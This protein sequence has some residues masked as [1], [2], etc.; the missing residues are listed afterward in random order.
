M[1]QIPFDYDKKYYKIMPKNMMH[2]KYKFKLGLNE[3]KLND[4]WD[5]R[6][7]IGGGFYFCNLSDVPEWIHLYP[8]G[9]I[10]DISIPHDAMVSKR[11]NKYKTNKI[12]VSNPIKYNDFILAH[13]LEYNVIESNGLY[14]CYIKKPTFDICMRAI[15]RCIFAI[16]Y[17]DIENQTLELCKKV[18]KQNGLLLEFIKNK[19]FDICI[20][21]IEQNSMALKFVP[22][23]YHNYQ[24][25]VMAIKQNP[26]ALKF[27]FLSM[28]SED[29]C[30]KLFE[31][32]IAPPKTITTNH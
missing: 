18:V 13:K 3:L 10:C 24:M 29:Q 12:F 31:L 2:D 15:E 4:P 17:I 5:P 20:D 22:R 14:L 21:A 8:N 27:I 16:K 11:S 30:N 6:E 1:D 9:I 7:C 32:A 19:T 25:Y 26:L 28:L 23:I